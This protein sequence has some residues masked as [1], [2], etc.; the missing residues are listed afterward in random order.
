MDQHIP[1]YNRCEEKSNINKKEALQEKWKSVLGWCPACWVQN[2]NG[3]K[4]S[5][6]RGEES[7]LTSVWNCANYYYNNGTTDRVLV[8]IGKI[9]N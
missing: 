7:F 2:L 8:P 1:E 9:G 4:R 3:S 5:T 6:L